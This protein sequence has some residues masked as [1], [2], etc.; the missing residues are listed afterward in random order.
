[1]EL[2]KRKKE[3]ILLVNSNSNINFRNIIIK[4]EKKNKESINA[5]LYINSEVIL[6]KGY[7]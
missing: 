1:M 3:F 7:I 2:M 5:I 6:K 4:T